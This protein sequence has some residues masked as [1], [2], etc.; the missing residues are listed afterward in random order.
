MEKLIQIHI[1]LGKYLIIGFLCLFFTGSVNGVYQYLQAEDSH[2]G[3]YC[4]CAGEVVDECECGGSCCS[5]GVNL[6][7]SFLAGACG[8]PQI[9]KAIT[10]KFDFIVDPSEYLNTFPNINKPVDNFKPAKGSLFI[11]SIEKPPQNSF[12][13]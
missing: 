9:I 5:S 8:Q 1:T 10:I 6:G 4:C 2:K 7:I 12:P 11:S 13:S 3:T